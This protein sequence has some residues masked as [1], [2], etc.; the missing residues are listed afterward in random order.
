MHFL[1]KSLFIIKTLNIDKQPSSVS[2]PRK[3]KL[4]ERSYLVCCLLKWKYRVSASRSAYIYALQFVFLGFF[5]LLAS[6]LPNF[7]RKR[8][9]VCRTPTQP[10][11]REDLKDLRLLC[12]KSEQ[13]PLVRPAAAPSETQLSALQQRTSSSSSSSRD[14]GKAWAYLLKGI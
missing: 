13:G 8:R 7:W 14:N 10:S 6:R 2:T 12:D 11:S 1:N 4:L 9:K 5:F 3:F